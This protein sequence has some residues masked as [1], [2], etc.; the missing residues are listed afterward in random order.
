LY[1]F[2][3]ILLNN[4]GMQMTTITEIKS[5]HN[6]D[7]IENTNAIIKP[8]ASFLSYDMEQDLI[9]LRKLLGKNGNIKVHN[10]TAIFNMSS[11]TDCPSRKLGIC[12]AEAQGAKCYAKKSERDY[13]PD[14][15]PYR[16]KQKDFWLSVSAKDFAFQFIIINSLRKKRTR[17]NALRF[18]EAGDFH[19]Q[20]C[21]NKAEKIARILKKYG[22]ICYCYTSRDDLDYHN[23]KALKISGSNFKKDGIVNIF[24][25]IDKKEDKPKGYGLCV[26]NCRKCNRCLRSGL[27]TAIIKH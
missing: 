4:G 24:K 23:V 12:K 8:I 21:V 18:N 10:T 17:F 13:R 7:F 20:K 16:E 27:K 26:G 22:I 6:N 19:D 5:T 9:P 11:A 3:I 2:G 1:L 25:I 14:V 15:K